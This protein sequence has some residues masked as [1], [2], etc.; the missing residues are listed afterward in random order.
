VQPEAGEVLRVILTWQEV[1]REELEDVG[2][3][4]NFASV[5]LNGVVAAAGSTI[6][7]WD[8]SKLSGNDSTCCT[9]ELK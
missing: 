2:I 5:C 7:I 1:L 9:V 3:F 4:A 8:A 6:E